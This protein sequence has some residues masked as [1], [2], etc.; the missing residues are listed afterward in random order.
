VDL[1]AVYNRVEHHIERRYGVPVW[2]A[3]VIDPNNG[4]V[5]GAEIQID[6]DQEIEI[7]L[8]VLIHLFG[9]TVQWNTSA[10]DRALGQD[11]QPGKS[12]AELELIG[13]YERDATRYSLSLLHE[14]GIYEL[15]DWASD[16]WHADWLYLQHFYRTGQKLH[17]P[18]LLRPGQGARLSP[19][20]I[21]PFVPQRY[22]SRW[23]F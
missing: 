7:A 19:L 20:P 22:P 10:A 5:N 16:W 21:P 9:H 12:E 17:A 4:D 18:S 8:F 1:A 6:Y 14:L 3:D 2:I 23:S 15:D 11:N 13:I